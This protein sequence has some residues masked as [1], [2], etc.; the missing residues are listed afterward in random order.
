MRTNDWGQDFGSRE[1]AMVPVCCIR[2]IPSPRERLSPRRFRRSDQGIR[3]QLAGTECHTDP[4]L[5]TDKYEC[6][7]ERACTEVEHSTSGLRQRAH[8]PCSGAFNCVPELVDVVNGQLL[9]ETHLSDCERFSELIEALKEVGGGLRLRQSKRIDTG[10]LERIETTVTLELYE[11]TD[12]QR[13]AVMRA[14]ADGYFTTSLETSVDELAAEFGTSTS[15]L[16]QRLKAV[17]S[18]LATRRVMNRVGEIRR[19]SHRLTANAPIRPP[20]R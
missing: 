1:L 2:D 14:V 6:P 19:E 9:I 4:T 20:A 15:A 7:S 12:K 17:E 3:Q 13:E 16:S 18:K 11:V 5:Q 10:V 8:V